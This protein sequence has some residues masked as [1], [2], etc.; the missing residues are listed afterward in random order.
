M[1]QKNKTSKLH[2][3]RYI[4]SMYSYLTSIKKIKQKAEYVYSYC[5]YELKLIRNPTGLKM[6]NFKTKRPTK[7]SKVHLNNFYCRLV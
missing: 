6:Y 7:P 3:F 2:T 4:V 5:T 1:Y